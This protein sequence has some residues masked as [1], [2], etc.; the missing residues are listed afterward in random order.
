MEN[1]QLFKPVPYF[2]HDLLNKIEGGEIGLPD[3]QRPFVWSTTKVR[4]LLD[5][6]YKGYPVGYF[7]FWENMPESGNSRF[8]GTEG[9]KRDTPHLLIIDGQ[10]RLTSLYAVFA[11]K[12]VLNSSY[13]EMQVAISFRPLDGKFEV[14][15]PATRKN[16]EFIP[17]VTD[18]LV[19][20]RNSFGTINSFLTSLKE[21][22]EVSGDEEQTIITNLNRLFGLYNYPF[23]A[24]EISHAVDEE[25]VA[26]IF[27]RINSEGVSLNQSDFILTLLSVFKEEAR[28]SVEGFCKA[29]L[30]PSHDNKPSP[31]NHFIEPNPADLL[32]VT[33]AY[34]FERGRLK[35]IYQVLRGKDPET[36]A[37]SVEL[38]K[39][40]FETFDV[41]QK[42]VLNLTSWHNFFNALIG[43][44]YRGNGMI[45]SDVTLMYCYALYLIGRHRFKVDESKLQRAIGKWFFTCSLSSRYVGSFESQMD[46]DLNRVKDLSTAAEYIEWIDK[47]I[48]SKLTNDYWEITL[49]SELETSSARSPHMFAFFAAQNILD[50]PV[51]FSSKKISS[52]LDP[53]IK[54]VKKNLEKHHLFPKAHLV[55]LGITDKKQINQLANITL[56]EWPDNI[57]VSDLPP[58][59]YIPVMQKRYEA[60]PEEWK[61]TCKLHALPSEWYNL[62]Y[63]TF[64]TQR[65]LLMAGVIREGFEKILA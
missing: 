46:A 39:K 30:K 32:R 20:N 33:A 1:Q 40:Q 61:R 18:V 53:A 51:L 63:Q 55:S 19:N 44:G 36:N 43:V 47:T 52:L 26:D 28:L 57:G 35:S 62:D 22:R 4:D 15:T 8:I 34:G 21:K 59:E 27:V 38:R 12:T 45:T 50:A 9:K 37:F 54:T 5:S 10:Q 6:M 23:T 2:L 25:D 13:K 58:H 3:I 56:L 64:L 60:Q 42:D 11:G 29:A 49:P 65:R 7:L 41:A 17:N 24:L 48:N 16:P 14:A 31:Y